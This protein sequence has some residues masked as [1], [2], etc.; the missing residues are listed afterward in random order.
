MGYNRVM[1][2]YTLDTGTGSKTGG[3]AI[4][5]ELYPYL[6]LSA[7]TALVVVVS[8][9]EAAEDAGDILDV[10]LQETLDGVTWNDRC[11]F[12]QLLGSLS[13]SASAP[14]TYQQTILALEDLTAA[15]YSFEPSGSAGGTRLVA[16]ATRNGPFAP[17]RRTETG[18]AAAYRLYIE[19][20][21]SDDDGG[22][23]GTITVRGIRA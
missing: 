9:S 12:P 23:T 14:E 5:S 19:V 21:D 3:S 13:P 7:L 4:T 2:E 6:D 22:F 8:L 17:R 18:P 20:T 1:H 16:G 11:R 10:A 15:D